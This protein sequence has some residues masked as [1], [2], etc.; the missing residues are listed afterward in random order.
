MKL[1]AEHFR[2]LED[3]VEDQQRDV[4]AIALHAVMGFGLLPDSQLVISSSPGS[5]AQTVRLTL[6]SCRAVLPGGYRVEINQDT[7]RQLQI[8]LSLPVVEFVATAGERFHVFLVVREGRRLPAGTPETRPIRHPYLVPDCTL[9]CLSQ[10]KARAAMKPGPNR[11]K[12]AEWQDGKLAEGYI[13]AILSLKGNALAFKWYLFFQSQLD[14]IVRFGNQVI[15]EHRIKDPARVAFC[16]PILS[17]I[18][19]TQGYF[20]WV[21][22]DK[23]PV[24]L[25]AYFGD[26]AGLV[27]SLLD[28]LDRDFV[29]NQLKDGQVNQLRACAQG[30]LKIPQLPFEETAA[31]FVYMQRFAEALQLTVRGLIT[32]QAPTPR[33]GERNISAG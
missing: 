4:R 28:T 16:M 7:F 21:L 31:V 18:R 25:I 14:A 26:L 10:E 32:Y 2:H 9:E 1:G 8:P 27:E 5:N 24:Y 3:S 30:F 29:R 17:S 11:M 23:P 6:E 20:K 22:P 33:S 19:Q 15:M 13:P 12:I